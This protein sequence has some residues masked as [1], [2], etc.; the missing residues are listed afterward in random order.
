LNNPK[1]S[2][3]EAMKERDQFED[4]VCGN[5]GRPFGA[6]PIRSDEGDC[7]EPKAAAESLPSACPHGIAND[8]RELKCSKCIA[9]EPESPQAAAPAEDRDWQEDFSNENGN[10]KNIC[11]DCGNIF[12]GHKR[13]VICKMCSGKAPEPA[14]PSELTEWFSEALTVAGELVDQ[15]EGQGLCEETD[16]IGRRANLIHI[17]LLQIAQSQP[18]AERTIAELRALVDR[19]AE[20]EGLWFLNPKTAPEAYLQQELRKLHAAIEETEDGWVPVERELPMER[21]LVLGFFQNYGT[22][23]THWFQWETME[24]PL[25]HPGLREWGEVTHWRPLPS[26]PQAPKGDK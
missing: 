26:P 3:G 4:D 20:D 5:C 22:A 9:V 12:R 18:A 14:T 2:R 19:Q 6:H 7:W 10:Y 15:C 11:T 13:R 24:S 1:H 25:W 21:Q 17:R 8:E 23:I 16:P